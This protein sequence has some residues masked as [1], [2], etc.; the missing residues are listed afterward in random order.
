MPRPKGLPK[1]GGRKAG[2]ANKATLLKQERRA[3]FDEEV[4]QVFIDTIHKA[5]PEY[6]LDQFM[7][8]APAKFEVE[9][10]TRVNPHPIPQEAIDIIKADLKRRMVNDE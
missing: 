2:T 6:L 5:R 7:G 10:T 4:S 3:I 1:T 9:A 8:K